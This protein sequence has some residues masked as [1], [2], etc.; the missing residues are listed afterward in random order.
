MRAAVLLILLLLLVGVVAANTL[1]VI[2]E[3]P[4]ASDL[5][6]C[7]E[8]VTC[9]EF[10][11][12][13][14]TCSIANWADRSI[15]VNNC[16]Q[17]DGVS[18]YYGRI[19]AYSCA[20]DAGPDQ[21]TNTPSE[22]TRTTV[23]WC[24]SGDWSS[25]SCSGSR[26]A[27]YCD[28]VIPS[29]A[30]IDGT[31]SWH[32][33]DF[34][35]SLRFTDDE[36]AWRIYTQ[37]FD[38]LGGGSSAET[39]AQT[40]SDTGSPMTCSDT[41]TIDVGPSSAV[42]D[43]SGSNACRLEGRFVDYWLFER[44]ASQTYD[45][46]VTPPTTTFGDWNRAPEC[47]SSEARC[48][49]RNW[50]QNTVG[51]ELTCTDEH[52]GCDTIWTGSSGSGSVFATDVTGTS[53]SDE[54]RPFLVDRTG[55]AA[56]LVDVVYYSDDNA[57]S[58][59]GNTESLRSAP[60]VWIDGV[61]PDTTIPQPTAWSRGDSFSVDVTCTDAGGSGC[62]TITY[63]ASNIG[64]NDMDC[65]PGSSWN[66]D[67]ESV[68]ET[69][70]HAGTACED[71]QI[72]VFSFCAYSTDNVGHDSASESITVS[73]DRTK[74]TMDPTDPDFD[75]DP[76]P[77]S[78]GSPT[79]DGSTD[80]WFND[81]FDVTVS[82][83]DDG[84]GIG[85]CYYQVN[86]GGWIEIAGC[87]SGSAVIGDDGDLSITVTF[88][89]TVGP[90]LMCESEGRD[91]CT[92]EFYA[93]DTVGNAMDP[94]S[95]TVSIDYTAPTCELRIVNEYQP[96]APTYGNDPF[97]NYSDTIKTH[98]YNNNISIATNDGT[99][100]YEVVM[101]FNDTTNADPNYDEVSGIMQI[102]MPAIT[103]DTS[104]ITDLDMTAPTFARH[105]HSRDYGFDPA[106]DFNGTATVQVTDEAGNTNT[107][108]FEVVQVPGGTIVI[109]DVNFTFSHTSL[110]DAANLGFD[111]GFDIE[112]D[113]YST[114]LGVTVGP[115]MIRVL[116][117][118]G[119]EAVSGGP[120]SYLPNCGPFDYSVSHY[121]TPLISYD[122]GLYD[123]ADDSLNA[124]EEALLRAVLASGAG[125]CFQPYL[126]VNDSVGNYQVI[127]PSAWPSGI[128]AW[129]AIAMDGSTGTSAQDVCSLFGDF[130]NCNERAR[131]LNGHPVDQYLVDSCAS[132]HE[133]TVSINRPPAAQYPGSLVS[134]L[135]IERDGYRYVSDSPSGSYR[136]FNIDADPA[137]PF[138]IQAA[139][140]SADT[141]RFAAQAKTVTID[142][143]SPLDVDA[144]TFPPVGDTPF[145]IGFRASECT[146]SC[147]LSTD[148][149]LGTCRLDCAGYNGCPN[150]TNVEATRALTACDG[151]SAGFITN[152][153]LGNN[154]L[155]CTSIANIDSVGE[156]GTDFT[157][158][159]SAIERN[160]RLVYIGGR[161]VKLVVVTFDRE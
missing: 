143:A 112:I 161:L 79:L 36:H 114:T 8:P 50:F 45:I 38:A 26:T 106:D 77:G 85:A 157:V 133:G 122:F 27:T 9:D 18:R 73:I 31:S 152:D 108:T 34:T 35:V 56:S 127:M 98:F 96:S 144:G 12:P 11:N 15:C 160:E 21:I 148:V 124:T 134:I 131:Y 22:T 44:T 13:A 146:S 83:V 102:I 117:S 16:S 90:G 109:N 155:C 41:V 40:C 86:G 52:S 136:L 153:G 121:D 139:P 63:D 33:D 128:D 99:G 125:R 2:V 126:V 78:G 24:A 23:T 92:I 6:I 17:Y 30:S 120:S 37:Q 116:N 151:L 84:S 69:Y 101:D 53:G 130:D 82:I 145:V 62:D 75:Y 59:P 100:D 91:T 118:S 42:C 156:V 141:L 39:L 71:D 87:N 97:Q 19:E 14:E 32:R 49:G 10:G 138:T 20:T 64:T 132:C 57:I 4:G 80:S 66:V 68:T 129:R 61:A 104:E 95:E 47:P 110:D 111:A 55:Q 28:C 51:Y 147:T 105:T 140:T 54:M 135:G 142:S 58:D 88:P 48:S 81:D 158:N 159:A 3:R 107:C 70:T 7:S 46:D 25:G 60:D 67:G 94:Y 123:E 74:P 115:A 5:T 137:R 89:V 113:A 65:S 119:V 93:E 29:A 103:N 149:G 43:T 150:S 76:T 154:Y 72:C 1:S